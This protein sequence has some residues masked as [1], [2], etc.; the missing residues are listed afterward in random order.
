MSQHDYKTVA[1]PRRAKK[2]KGVKGRDAQ[3]ALAVE[4]IIRAEAA[5]GWE[6]VR[7]DLFEAEEAGGLFSKSRAVS[8]SVMIFRRRNAA[9]DMA[10][11]VVPQPTREPAPQPAPAA[12]EPPRAASRQEPRFDSPGDSQPRP[13]KHVPNDPGF[14]I[15]GVE[16]PSG[17][18]KS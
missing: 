7:T 13:A 9:Q 17:D 15:A 8:Y 18:R 1:A 5:N 4:D 2:V 3:F 16:A 6:Y 14:S 12:P 10:P 11:T